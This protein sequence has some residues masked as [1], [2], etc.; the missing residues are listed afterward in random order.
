MKVIFLDFDGVLN[1]NAF[2]RSLSRTALS[3]PAAL[4]NEEMIDP[5][6]VARLQRLID[7]TDAEIVISS[8]W[9]CVHGIPELGR[10]LAARGCKRW[11]YDV[12]PGTFSHRPR[13]QEIREWLYDTDEEVSA[14]VVLDDTRDAVIEGH[15]VLTNPK[16]GLT[17]ADVERA[18]AILGDK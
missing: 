13:S 12:T 14:F 7:A 6:N 9:R 8:S 5:V 16:V 11:P 3:T 2:L 4:C 1:S 17:D 15:T 10:V 18:I